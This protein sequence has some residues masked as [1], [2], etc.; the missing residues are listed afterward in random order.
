LRDEITKAMYGLLEPVFKENYA[1][2]AEVINVFKITKVGQIAGCRVTDGVITRTAQVRVLREGEEV[3]RGKI[4]SLKR[5]K[6]DASEVRQ[7]VE[8][9]IDLAGFKDIRVGDIIESFTTEKLADELGQNSIAARKQEK[10]EKEAAAAAA[11]EA[12]AAAAEAEAATE[13]N[14]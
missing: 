1:G 12:E 3:W 2:K 11:V 13:A 4:G 9:G 7:G 5:F 8:C 6:D 14:A 10:A